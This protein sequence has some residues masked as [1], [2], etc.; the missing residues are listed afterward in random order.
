MFDVV[1]VLGVN[2]L[3]VFLTAC[4]HSI[5]VKVKVILQQAM[6]VLRVE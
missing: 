4:V 6:K 1:H 3:A 5:M 2:A